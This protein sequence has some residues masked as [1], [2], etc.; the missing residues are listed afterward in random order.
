V[1]LLAQVHV[2]APE[3]TEVALVNSE[4]WLKTSFMVIVLCVARFCNQTVENGDGSDIL[5]MWTT[6]RI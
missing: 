2:C 5:F 4:S 6:I 1:Q 3:E